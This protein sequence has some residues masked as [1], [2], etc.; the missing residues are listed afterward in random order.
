MR[1]ARRSTKPSWVIYL[2]RVAILAGLYACSGRLGLLLHPVSKFATLVWAPAGL[3]L[4]F[5]LLFG[6]RLWPGVALG[7]MVVNL[8]AGAPI[9]VALA[10]SAGNTFEALCGVYALQRVGFDR[11]LGRARDAIAFVLLPS[12]LSPLV[13]AT[14]GVSALLHGGLIGWAHVAAT[15][16][17][18][19]LGDALGVL[20][21]APLVLT[22]WSGRPWPRN[23]AKEVEAAALIVSVIFVSVFVFVDW[24]FAS[25]AGLFRRAYLPMPFVIWA[26]LRFEQRGAAV[27]TFLQAT[28]V[29]W[30]TAIG[31]GPFQP[32][33]SAHERLVAAQGFTGVVAMTSLILG[34]IVSENQRTARALREAHDDLE[35]RVRERTAELREGQ[36]LLAEAQNIAHVG[37]WQWDIEADRIS[38]SDELKRIHGLAPEEFGATLEGFARDHLHPEDRGRV[39]K[40]VASAVEGRGPLAWQHRIVRPDGSVRLLQLHAE[41]QLGPDGRPARLVGTCQDV[42]AIHENERSLEKSMKEKE[43]LVREVHHRVKNN[44]QI[45]SSLLSLHG[46]DPATRKVFD[47]CRDRI[48]AM[49]LVHEKLHQSTS[50]VSID[51]ASY[52]KSLVDALFRMNAVSSTSI[53]V[54]VHAEGSLEM[55]T[56]IPCGLIVTELVSN[57]LKHAF[58]DG[59]SGR[60]SVALRP[61]PDGRHLVLEVVDDGVGFPLELDFRNAQ[62]LGLKLVGMLADQ[63]GGAIELDT[64]AGTRLRI[65]FEAS[66]DL[67]VGDSGR[68][69]L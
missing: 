5:L 6:A 67:H 4:A 16:R 15:W 7:A 54:D 9:L 31:R 36:K 56:A 45:V 66:R 26:A 12:L 13:G 20:V 39:E 35:K 60:I 64:H 34:A 1:G 29:T 69:S 21:I 63:L 44:L 55:D 2:G 42:T 10:I 57:A 8:W 41:V 46:R 61:D 49:S 43:L 30:G 40:L 47:D 18:W 11:R 17:A 51:A 19:W 25:K 50:M 62:T 14:I 27:V 58:P 53:A 24:P 23:V 38:W 65:R 59:R 32:L 37:S 48:R 33:P 52:L 22:L 68:N 28:V 3:S